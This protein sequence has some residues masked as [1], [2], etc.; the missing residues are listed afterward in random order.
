MHLRYMGTWHVVQVGEHMSYMCEVLEWI[1][2]TIILDKKKI[3]PASLARVNKLIKKERTWSFM[4]DSG[5]N[6]GLLMEDI[7]SRKHF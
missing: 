6:E 5:F 1:S 4:Y 3:P 7:C 2:S